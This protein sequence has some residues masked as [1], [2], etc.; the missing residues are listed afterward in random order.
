MKLIATLVFLALLAA[1]AFAVTLWDESVNGDLSSNAAAPTP[2]PLIA[3]S[4]TI[5]GTMSSAA[6][7]DRDYITFTIDPDRMLTDIILRGLS[8][9]NLAFTAVNSGAT[10]FVPSASTSASFL[11][12]THVDAGDIGTSIL[13][14][15]QTSSVTTNHLNFPYLTAGTYSFLMQQTSPINQAYELE[16]VNTFILGAKPGSWGAIKKLYR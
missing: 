16:F 12:G 10:S 4:N 13:S 14:L 11:A 2:I 1:P 8:P 15:F 6:G 3:A 5:V 9:D 7:V